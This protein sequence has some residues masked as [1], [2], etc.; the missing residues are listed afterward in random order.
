MEIRDKDVTAWL[1]NLPLRDAGPCP[2]EEFLA[3]YLENSLTGK[4][5]DGVMRHVLS[6]ERCRAAVSVS[7][8]EIPRR[9]RVPAKLEKKAV[10]LAPAG[11][12][13]WEIVVKFAE[14]AIEVIKNTG[15]RT[16]YFAPVYEFARG[17]IGAGA[18]KTLVVFNRR[19]AGLD[20]EVEI[21]RLTPVTSDIKVTARNLDGGG[22]PRNLRINLHRGNWEE[23]MSYMLQGGSVTFDK[24]QHGNYHIDF[25]RRGIRL[26]E[27]ALEIKGE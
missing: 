3:S 24:I 18:G 4:E 11:E 25:T 2:D 23:I 19:F 22:Y 14:G 6:C 21:E 5:R 27:I 26:G 15:D 17:E 13:I 16:R 7:A 9:V 20:A 10:E 8:G 12:G 1:R